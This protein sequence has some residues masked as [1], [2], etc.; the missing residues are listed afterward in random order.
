MQEKTTPTLTRFNFEGHGQLTVLSWNGQPAWIAQEVIEVLN[1][2]QV[3]PALQAA[4]LTEGVDFIVLKGKDYSNL[5]FASD[6]KSLANLDLGPKTRHLALL[7]ESGLYSLIMR[8]RKPVAVKFRNWVT[9]EVLPA[10]RT[11]GFYSLPGTVR[12]RDWNGICRLFDQASNGA[13]P[14]SST[15][16]WMG[17][18]PQGDVPVEYR[19]TPPPMILSKLVA[20]AQGGNPYAANYLGNILHIPLPP[21]LQ[22]DLPGVSA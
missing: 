16:A 3:H 19:V 22:M 4:K 1:L 15:L 8:S 21:D 11:Q 2:K 18:T 17:F 6:L 13:A 7:F 14:A 10:L 12:Y 9:R 20:L 5:A